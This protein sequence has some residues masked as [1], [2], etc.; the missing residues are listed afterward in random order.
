MPPATRRYTLLILLVLAQ[1][2][3]VYAGDHVRGDLLA[4]RVDDL[5][6]TEGIRVDELSSFAR[7]ALGHSFYPDMVLTPD[8]AGP[9]GQS[10]PPILIVVRL[11]EP[12]YVIDAVVAAVRAGVPAVVLAP[13]RLLQDR[14]AIATDESVAPR[15][16][17]R[18][19]ITAA[20]RSS[21]QV[22][23][24]EAI[25]PLGLVAAAAE[26]AIEVDVV[27][28]NA[29]HLGFGPSDT[30]LE[31]LAAAG[32]AGMTL[33]LGDEPTA[34]DGDGDGAIGAA[35]AAGAAAV[36]VVGVALAAT[37]LSDWGDEVAYL[38]VG[39]AGT[40]ILTVGELPLVIG[41][42]AVAVLSL[43]FAVARARQVRRYMR[44]IGHNAAPIL[45]LYLVLVG[46]LV[47]AGRLLALPA[48]GATAASYPV[49]AVVAR[50]AL[51]VVTIGIVWP[52]LHVRMRR[53]TTAYT[54]MAIVLLIG[55]TLA[56]AAVS[57]VLASFFVLT[58]VIAILF[59]LTRMAW[60]KLAL[61]GLAAAPG[62]YLL[63]TFTLAGDPLLTQALIAPPIVRDAQIALL[64]MPVL[65]MFFRVDVLMPRV[66]IGGLL[67]MIAAISC[68]I[69]AATI[70]TGL[71]SDETYDPVPV[72]LPPL[73]E[74]RAS[75]ARALTREVITIEWTDAARVTGMRFRVA[76]SAP[77]ELYATDIPAAQPLGSRA[78]SFTFEPGPYPP[79]E[80]Q[81][82]VV[83]LPDGP[84]Q[85][86]TITLVASSADGATVT[87][88]LDVAVE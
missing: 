87:R 85:T 72:V 9:D 17:P 12:P 39:G 15:A 62:L 16:V 67:T 25:A 76:A 79:A 50:A 20:A 37:P 14:V 84:L 73:I 63:V 83:L 44:A 23:A 64:A 1:S 58:L 26:T 13:R 77:V 55:G 86:V 8:R 4:R 41:T 3:A 71:G 22:A 61:V 57:V 48:V 38:A 6:A 59:S 28:L 11:E 24:G 19:V 40:P 47:A 21:W 54:G 78:T 68:A 29:T 35:A 70:I 80:G 42:L 66:P 60:L 31:G 45:L 53:A 65:L 52:L 5:Q 32:V 2:L 27:G 82:T 88:R 10:V 18:V 46:A 75:S 7:N 34:G 81:T 74:V 49:A 33:R 30:L 36:G 56:A 69:A 51:G 43:L